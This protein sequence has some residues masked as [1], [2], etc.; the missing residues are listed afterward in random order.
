[1]LNSLAS[2][3]DFRLKP[4]ATIRSATH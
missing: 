2:N 4:E 3:P 1:M